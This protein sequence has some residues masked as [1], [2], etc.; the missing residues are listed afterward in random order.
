LF[1]LWGLNIV[2]DDGLDKPIYGDATLV[3]RD[4]VVS[5]ASP[6]PEAAHLLSGGGFRDFLV[7]TEA[8]LSH[9]SVD[10]LV[11]MAPGS[12]IAVRRKKDDEAARYAQSIRA[13]LSGSYVLTGGQ[14]K[15]FSMNPWSMHWS[16]IPTRVWQTAD[17]RTS[18][19]YEISLA[20]CL[21]DL[22]RPNLVN[23]DLAVI[24]AKRDL[25]G[26]HRG[27]IV[28]TTL[29]VA[30]LGGVGV[31]LGLLAGLDTSRSNHEHEGALDQSMDAHG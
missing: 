24:G 18:C 26:P 17:G 6:K 14:P 5:R 28:L 2:G 21:R 20:S 12:F 15:G 4:F 11:E 13:F 7:R 1:P 16:A 23:P 30:G 3:S 10:N 25:L 9:V 31:T 19:D 8:N 22:A 27:W 29:G